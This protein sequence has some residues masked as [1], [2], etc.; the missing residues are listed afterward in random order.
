MTKTP[1]LLIREF[2]E[3]FVCGY[4]LRGHSCPFACSECGTAYD[5][6]TIVCYSPY[7]VSN[8]KHAA[9]FV[10]IV[11]AIGFPLVFAFSVLVFRPGGQML[12]TVFPIIMLVAVWEL[13]R[14]FRHRT[15]RQRPFIGLTK[16]GLIVNRNGIPGAIEVVPWNE[17]RRRY[18]TVGAGWKYAGGMID[19]LG[20]KLYLDD[21]RELHTKAVDFLVHYPQ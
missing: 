2:Q 9:K 14:R 17:A 18:H 20:P 4:S 8:P 19:D 21:A 10:V 5:A 11:A 15:S 6:N 3:C 12:R 16:N 1:S 13:W 7:S